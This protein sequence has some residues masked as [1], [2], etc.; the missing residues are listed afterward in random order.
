MYTLTTCFWPRTTVTRQ[1][2]TSLVSSANVTIKDVKRADDIGCVLFCGKR[3]CG[4]GRYETW[5]DRVCESLLLARR[6]ASSLSP[7]RA[8][9]VYHQRNSRDAKYDRE[10][11]L[12]NGRDRPDESFA[13]SQLQ[14]KHPAPLVSDPKRAVQT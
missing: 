5:G 1:N 3:V 8:N 2:F 12:G 7:T 13:T 11:V 6:C 4:A 9:S 10:F 14:R